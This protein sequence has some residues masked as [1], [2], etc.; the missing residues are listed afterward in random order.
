MPSRNSL[1]A[2]GETCLC[3]N[4]PMKDTNCHD[5]DTS[6]IPISIE[7]WV[8]HL[9]RD[10]IE[11]MEAC[12]IVFG[13]SYAPIAS[14]THVLTK[15]GVYPR[16]VFESSTI[17]PVNI[18][19]SASPSAGLTLLLLASMASSTSLLWKF[20]IPEVHIIDITEPNSVILVSE[21]EEWAPENYDWCEWGGIL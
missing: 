13:I 17:M 20:L 2:N 6:A 9:L 3:I 12:W 10:Q 21:D 14:G 7:H 16:I 15:E 8:K 5:L 18:R 4:E 1:F 19:F 11:S